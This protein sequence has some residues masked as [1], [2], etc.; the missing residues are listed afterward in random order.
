MTELPRYRIK[1]TRKGWLVLLKRPGQWLWR[2]FYPFG[3]RRLR[4][5]KDELTARW[6]ANVCRRVDER[7]VTP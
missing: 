4:F 5:H 3:D 1:E 6:A 2:Q 7:N